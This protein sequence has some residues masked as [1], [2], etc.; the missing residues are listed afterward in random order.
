M[1]I[2]ICNLCAVFAGGVF[3]ENIEYLLSAIMI[4]ARCEIHF[5][6]GIELVKRRPNAFVAVH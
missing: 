5:F 1:F 2:N 6:V 3:T 4:A